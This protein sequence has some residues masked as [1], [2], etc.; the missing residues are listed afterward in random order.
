MYAALDMLPTHCHLHAPF[1]CNTTHQPNT[2]DCA[3]RGSCRWSP[4]P[5]HYSHTQRCPSICGGCYTSQP[6]QRYTC[7]DDE[8]D[9]GDDDDDEEEDVNDDNVNEEEEEEEG[10]MQVLHGFMFTHIHLSPLTTPH[11]H[12]DLVFIQNGMLQPWLD[13]RNLGNNT[14]VLVFFAVAAKGDPPLDGK[15]EVNPEGLTAA[16]GPHATAVA[17][18]LHAHGLSCKVLDRLNFQKSMLEKLV[19]ICAFML[20]GAKHGGVSVGE[21]ESTY[22]AEV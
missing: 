8:D 18:R 11:S 10:R 20:V 17:A 12:I 5:H 13:A 19:W 2:G 22:N 16:H 15:T 9:D 21:V 14:Q 7:D 3:T 4:R 1:V 6:P